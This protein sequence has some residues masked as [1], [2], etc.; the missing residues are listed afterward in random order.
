MK[1]IFIILC[2]IAISFSIFS[3]ATI[4][5][6][7]GLLNPETIQTAVE[8]SRKIEQ[9]YDYTPEETYD[10]GK[11]VAANIV[12]TYNLYYNETL[13]TYLSQICQSIVINSNG[14][15]PYKGYFIG[16]LDT[17]EINA[18]ATPGGHILITRGMLKLVKSED[19]LAAVIAHEISHI[20]L[21]HSMKAIKTNTVTQSV[22]AI[23]GT[24]A[25]NAIKETDEF[26][27]YA[28]QLG[29]EK[30]NQRFQAVSTTLIN[31]GYSQNTEFDA[32]KNAITLMHNTG[33]N[34]NAM[35]TMLK[36]L[37]K[38]KSKNYT[39]GFGKTHPS[40]QLRISKVK[41]KIKFSYKTHNY[42][43]DSRTERFEKAKQYF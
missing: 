40:P 32:D 39:L 7:A 43:E 35:K 29:G 8:S 3:C 41:G 21:E 22:S 30:L 1:N 27:K 11:L 4:H 9:V 25:K 6:I 23:T 31:S 34:P 16:V 24:F 10:L 33:Y 18:F 26:G 19:E 42:N 2:V 13:Q 12:A 37:K 28:M 17:D 38:N 14:F 15:N 20:Q 36:A 5:H